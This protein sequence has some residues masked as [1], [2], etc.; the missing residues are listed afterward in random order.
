MEVP[1]LDRR[2]VLGGVLG[3]RLGE[4]LSG[5]WVVEEVL[6]QHPLY[7]PPSFTAVMTS[8]T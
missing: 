2:E 7:S 4:C 3:N 1:S 6:N 5:T 8:D